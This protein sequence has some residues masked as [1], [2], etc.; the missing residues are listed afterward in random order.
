MKKLLVLLIAISAFQ[1]SAQNNS[2][3]LKHYKAFY[4]QMR[5]QGDVQ[6]VIN[7]LTHINVLQPSIATRDTLAVYYMNDGKYVQAL[8]TI[9]IDKNADDSDLAVEVKAVSLQALN[10]PKKA[11]EHFEVLFKRSPNVMIAYEMADLKIQTNDLAGATTS[12]N[13]GLTNSTD[14]MVRT[15]YDTQ[16]PYKVPAKAAFKYLSAIV[17]YKENPEQNKDAAFA[18][19][20]EAEQMAPNFNRVK[21]AKEA[22]QA[23]M[24]DKTKE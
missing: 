7:A 14:E 8:N 3:L 9:G 6:G 15:Y 18:I 5:T 19:L 13:F 20:N 11:L 4:Q 21:V 22:I 17:K 2:E 1:V 24:K 23:Q 10:Q 16:S 12:I